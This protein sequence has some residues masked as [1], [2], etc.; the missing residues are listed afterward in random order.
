MLRDGRDFVSSYRKLKNCSLDEAINRWESAIHAVK[1]FSKKGRPILE[2]KYEDF[3]LDTEKSLE[4]ICD[5]LNIPYYKSMLENKYVY[6]G[7]DV[8]AHHQKIFEPIDSSS[9]GRWKSDLTNEEQKIVECRIAD[10]LYEKD[11]L[12]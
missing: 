3:I 7:D 11:Y 5:F 8:L 6:L 1:Y 2:M 9:I 12:K 4:T 10:L